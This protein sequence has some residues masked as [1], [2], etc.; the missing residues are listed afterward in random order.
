VKGVAP[1]EEEETGKKGLAALVTGCFL[2]ASN[3]LTGSV[4][5]ENADV[6]NAKE[7]ACN[8]VTGA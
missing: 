5:E 8:P 2:L 3:T 6:K 1:Y 7:F 4:P